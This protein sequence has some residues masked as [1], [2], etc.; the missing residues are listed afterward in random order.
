L[1]DGG[2]WR[3]YYG[4]ENYAGK[5]VTAQTALQLS[6]V[7]GCVRLLSEVVGTL[8]L[9]LYTR[10]GQ[11]RRVL[12]QDHPLYTILHD[13]PNANMTPADFWKCM[14]AC[15][16]LW[17]NAYALI[18]RVGKRIVALE[19]LQPECMIV[20]TNANGALEFRYT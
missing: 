19:P 7:W 4:T 2:F 6:A 5:T 1:T 11:G 15:I 9:F 14:I 3:W 10:D 12:A 13:S 16:A 18:H 20:K 8:P 17:G